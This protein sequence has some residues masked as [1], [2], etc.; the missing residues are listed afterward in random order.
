MDEFLRV[1]LLS[2]LI[3]HKA[4]WE[5]LKVRT[6]TK[7]GRNSKPGINLPFLMKSA[8]VILLIFIVLQ[9]ILMAPVYPISENPEWIIRMGLFLYTLGLILA[10]TGR[11]QLGS[12]WANIEESQGTGA[13][14]L[15]NQGIFKFI[16]HP[17]YTGDALL[18]LGLELALNSWFFLIIIPLMG[19]ILNRARKEERILAECNP[20]YSS[21][22]K[23]TKM[24][25]PF[26][27]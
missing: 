10:I 24:F 16:R 14:R 22:Q 20:E 5:I 17:I 12:S 1:Y 7:K 8:K 11:I 3:V 19:V 15:V 23:Q 26:I 9:I 21:Y 13:H 4:V 25:L 18:I 2:G 27:V 6:G